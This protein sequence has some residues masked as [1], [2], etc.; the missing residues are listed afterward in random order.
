[1]KLILTA[2]WRLVVAGFLAGVIVAA[3][4]L[5]AWLAIR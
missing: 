4:W 3:A 5:V 2:M 1:V